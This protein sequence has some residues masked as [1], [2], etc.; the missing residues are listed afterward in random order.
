M[1]RTLTAV[2]RHFCGKLL[3]LWEEFPELFSVMDV[4]GP[5]LF[6][7]TNEGLVLV[8]RSE[9]QSDITA[10]TG[11][12]PDDPARTE[13]HL[14]RYGIAVTGEWRSTLVNA[15]ETVEEALPETSPDDPKYWRAKIR[16]VRKNIPSL[17]WLI[18]R[19]KRLGEVDESEKRGKGSHGLLSFRRHGVQ[20]HHNTWQS[21]RGTEAIHRGL[22]YEILHTFCITERE[23]YETCLVK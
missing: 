9:H 6:I 13:E 17:D 7:R 5:L 21:I 4:L 18:E 15:V 19:L 2:D 12:A 1:R 3:A 8:F 22:L 23:F 14:R 20:H 11:T 10:S 16:T